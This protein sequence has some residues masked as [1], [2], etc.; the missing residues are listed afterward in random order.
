MYK[1]F[2][3]IFKTDN[4]IFGLDLLRFAAIVLVV[5][6]HARWM[7]ATFPRPLRAILHGSGILGVELFFVLSGFL[8]G[9]ILL[10]Q[11]EKNNF[12]LDFNAVKNLGIRLWF[13]TLPTYYLIL[14]V[15]VMFYFL[16][17]P[18][19]LMAFQKK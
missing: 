9:G 3:D 13:S 16:D 4:R 8:I 2:A 5:L 19:N 12:A 15:Y 17:I 10:K 14:M 6:G 7:T 1:R 11:F 18:A